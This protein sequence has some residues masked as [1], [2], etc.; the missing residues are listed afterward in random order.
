MIADTADRRTEDQVLTQA[1]RYHAR[2]ETQRQQRREMMRQKRYR[3]VTRAIRRL[4][5]T[6]P[7]IRAVYLFGSLLQ[8]GHFGPRSD[9]DVAVA[10]DDP[11]IESYFWHSLETSL[12]CNVDLR[13]YQGTVAWAV[14]TSG[15]C[16]YVRKV[17]PPRT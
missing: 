3:Q 13:P 15:E 16:V 9:I 4:A 2:R 6:Y 10:G 11:T 1:R 5:P 12:D 14:N 17:S 8:P 7:A